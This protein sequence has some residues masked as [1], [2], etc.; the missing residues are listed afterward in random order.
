MLEQLGMKNLKPFSNHFCMPDADVDVGLLPLCNKQDVVTI[1]M[2]I[3]ECKKGKEV[4][5][6]SKKLRFDLNQPGCGTN[7]IDVDVLS[8]NIQ[9]TMAYKKNKQACFEAS[10]VLL[11]DT[12]FTDGLDFDPLFDLGDQRIPYDM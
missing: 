1:S 8:S 10:Q 4:G 9:A 7:F 11:N 3:V 6:C 5:S 2:Y 12:P